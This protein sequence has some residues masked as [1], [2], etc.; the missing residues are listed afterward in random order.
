MLWLGL[1]LL[2]FVLLLLWKWY[3]LLCTKSL[4][5]LRWLTHRW[6]LLCFLQCIPAY[7]QKRCYAISTTCT[8][9]CLQT[10]VITLWESEKQMKYLTISINSKLT[11]LFSFLQCLRSSDWQEV[12][13]HYHYCFHFFP[14]TI[15]LWVFPRQRS[16]LIH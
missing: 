1:I 12:H 14:R 10:A 13:C 6:L 8:E 16:L 2:L 11:I 5:W 9:T 15:L 7:S 4:L 3:T